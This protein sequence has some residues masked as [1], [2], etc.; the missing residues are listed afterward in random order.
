MN[1]PH[2][3]SA[4]KDIHIPFRRALGLAALWLL[5]AAT[6]LLAGTIQVAWSPVSNP[7]LAGYRIFVGTSPESGDIQIK[8]VSPS[9][10]TAVID[11]LPDCVVL[12][13]AVKAF[14]L[15]GNESVSFSNSISGMTKPSI[16]SVT[17]DFVEQ[18]AEF[19]NLQF[20][21]TGFSSDLQRADVSFDDPDLRILSVTPTSCNSLVVQVSVGPFFL[22]PAD[23]RYGT[24]AE[25]AEDVAPVEIGS[26]NVTLSL[27]NGAGRDEFEIGSG[28]A[29][30]LDV[31]RADVNGSGRT[32]GFDLALLGQRYGNSRCPAGDATCV[33]DYNPD[34]D[35]DG[36]KSLDGVDLSILGQ[37]FG[38][39]F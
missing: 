26:R 29:I 34:L 36:N 28:L 33:S 8:T 4:A 38:Q 2:S 18:G 16:S 10:T 21:G 6:P 14:D 37:F 11:Q 13:V 27:P 5:A 20:N 30:D 24:L 19:V 17:P 23:P 3:A 1:K 25:P 7:D 22:D 31:S 32:D 35:L 15:S 9:E 12:F 39:G